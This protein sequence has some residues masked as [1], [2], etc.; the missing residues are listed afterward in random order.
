[1]GNTVPGQSHS[2]ECQRKGA[3]IRPHGKLQGRAL[4]VTQNASVY[5]LEEP[6]CMTKRASSVGLLG[7]QEKRLSDCWEALAQ[8]RNVPEPSRVR[9]V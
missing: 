7:Q 6:L 4:R 5:L 9:Q 1:M 3:T 2:M 8:D